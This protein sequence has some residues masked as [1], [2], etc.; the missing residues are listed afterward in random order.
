[1]AKCSFPFQFEV[2][3]PLSILGR[4]LLFPGMR[5]WEMEG[6]VDI[7]T[8]YHL[9]FFSL[10]SPIFFLSGYLCNILFLSLERGQQT[11]SVKGQKKSIS[12]FEGRMVL[13]TTTYFYHYN[14]KTSKENSYMNSCVL[15][16]ICL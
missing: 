9:H 3:F 12:D 10:L 8:P 16:K 1:M 13:V 4:F 2:T 6:E 14:K 7:L 5:R 15:I 11:F